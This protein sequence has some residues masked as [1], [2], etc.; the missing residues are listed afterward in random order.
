MREEGFTSIYDNVTRDINVCEGKPSHNRRH[1]CNDSEELRFKG[2]FNEI[3]DNILLQIRERFKSI[4]NFQF[5]SLLN[6]DFC[7]NYR[8]KFPDSDVSYLQKT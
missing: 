8:N 5:F 7:E 2:L 6:C 1:M 3:L 4:A